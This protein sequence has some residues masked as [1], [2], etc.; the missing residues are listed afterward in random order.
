MMATSALLQLARLFPLAMIVVACAAQATPRIA[1]PSATK[2]VDAV[3]TEPSTASSPAPSEP[4]SPAQLEGEFPSPDATIPPEEPTIPNLTVDSLAATATA[5]GLECTSSYGG[6]P[7][8]EGGYTLGCEGR[9][10]SGEA[11]LNLSAL[12]YT[13]DGI[14]SVRVIVIPEGS[15]IGDPTIASELILPV[16]SLA[17]GEMGRQWIAERMDDAGCKEGCRSKVRGVWLTLSVAESG[18]RLLHIDPIS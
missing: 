5:L 13:M 3:T 15:E 14:F 11:S 8:G 18:F 6:P 12:Y 7:E 16:A 10:A 9:D 17:A 1:S 2:H 4:P